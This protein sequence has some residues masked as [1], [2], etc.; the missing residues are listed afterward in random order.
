MTRTLAALVLWL[1]AAQPPAPQPPQFRSG[2]ERIIIDVQ[3]VDDAGQPIDTLTAGDFDVQ[4]DRH[5]RTVVAAQFIRSAAI[6]TPA[7]G[8]AASP[9][10]ANYVAHA[11]NRGAR[12]YILAVDE[13]SFRAADA[14][15]V[16]RAAKG[17]IAS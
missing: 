2:V 5:P 10:V 9:G 3:V 14:P 11:E 13:S 16:M 7:A 8:A 1:Q 6:D 12:D 17:F 15:A 4:F